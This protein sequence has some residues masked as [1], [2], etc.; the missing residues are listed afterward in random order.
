MSPFYHRPSIRPAHRHPSCFTLSETHALCRFPSL[1]RRGSSLLQSLVKPPAPLLWLYSSDASPAK[2]PNPVERS[3]AL[4]TR[5]QDLSEPVLCSTHGHA[6]REGPALGPDGFFLLASPRSWER[7]PGPVA[8]VGCGAGSGATCT[9]APRAAG[10]QHP[11][12]RTGP[13]ASAALRFAAS[14]LPATL[15]GSPL[16]LHR[17]RLPALPTGVSAG[18]WALPPPLMSRFGAAGGGAAAPK[19]PWMARDG[20]T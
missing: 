2:A 16:D 17:F 9:P 13:S 18:S 6:G 11:C 5:V 7:T 3:R 8:G 4:T 20:D 19:A 10:L 14:D 1:Q 15:R 12:T